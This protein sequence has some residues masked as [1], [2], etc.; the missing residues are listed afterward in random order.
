MLKEEN[1]TSEEV[2]ISV[3]EYRMK[4]KFASF[5]PSPDASLF[6]YACQWP[7]DCAFLIH[8]CCPLGGIPDA[9]FCGT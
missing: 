7:C 4:H 9:L 2:S 5:L 8:S 3:C 6:N 1:S